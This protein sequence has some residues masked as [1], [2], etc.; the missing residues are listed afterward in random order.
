[1]DDTPYKKIA[2]IL[3]RTIINEDLA[4]QNE[5]EVTVT[6]AY[7]TAFLRGYIRK[8][9][10]KSISWE[11]LEAKLEKISNQVNKIYDQST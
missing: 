11:I 10:K 8:L 2:A 3:A 5:L 1:M 4:T 9:T 6:L 7:L